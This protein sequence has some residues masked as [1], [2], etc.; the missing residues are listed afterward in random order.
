MYKIRYPVYDREKR[1]ILRMTIFSFGYLD[2]THPTRAASIHQV[3][4]ERGTSL[5]C[6]L[7]AKVILYRSTEKRD[8]EGE[9]EG[10]REK[11]RERRRKPA[12]LR[13]ETKSSLADLVLPISVSSFTLRRT[14][15]SLPWPA[16]R[17][18]WNNAVTLGQIFRHRGLE[19]KTA[20][21]AGVLAPG[22]KRITF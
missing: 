15:L 9:R 13:N 21:V 4:S 10:G 17:G 3:H 7:F 22:Q 1:Q 11:E 18:A 12:A 20:V 5:S 19:W 2:R 6:L 14:P 16:R 8:R